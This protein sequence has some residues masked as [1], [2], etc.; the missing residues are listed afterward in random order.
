MK[1]VRVALLHATCLLV[2]FLILTKYY[3]NM[4]KGIKVM[5]R[6]KMSYNFCFRGENYITNIVRVV[7]LTYNTPTG[8][9]FHPYQVLSNY[10]KQYGSYG[11]H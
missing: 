4:S 9:T 5:E 6:I 10:L 2:L 7:S 1:T 8:P 3:Q 11:L